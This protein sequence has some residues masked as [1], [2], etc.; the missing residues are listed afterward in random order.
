MGMS[1]RP[2]HQVIACDH[3]P[4]DIPSHILSYRVSYGYIAPL[5]KEIFAIVRNISQPVL[6]PDTILCE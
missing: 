4:H 1:C 5:L 2:P 6:S 3:E